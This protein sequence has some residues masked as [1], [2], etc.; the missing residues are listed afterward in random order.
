MKS[1]YMNSGLESS[2]N[3]YLLHILHNL[4]YA[5]FFCFATIYL[6]IMKTAEKFSSKT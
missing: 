2:R 3:S 1:L 6:F 5:T 4:F